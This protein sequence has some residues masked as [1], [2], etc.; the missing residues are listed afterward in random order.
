MTGR[1]PSVDVSEAPGGFEPV[2]PHCDQPL[3]GVVRQQIDEGFGKAYV[4]A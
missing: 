4:W 2:C 3:A 1:L